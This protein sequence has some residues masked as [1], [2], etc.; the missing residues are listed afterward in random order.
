LVPSPLYRLYRRHQVRG[1]IESFRPRTVEHRYGK[2]S[3]RVR[4]EDPLAE[5]WYDQDWDEPPEVAF[6]RSHGLSAG[7]TVFDLGAHQGVVA[8]LLA[9]VVG[10]SGSV[11][12]VEATSHNA[13]VA[14]INRDLNGATQVTIRHAAVA[15]EP[16]KVFVGEELN[17]RA[18]RGRI[19]QTETEAITIDHLTV[20]HGPPDAILVDV[21][22]FEVEALRGAAATL[23]ARPALAIEVHTG[24][25]LE[26]AGGSVD[27]LLGLL[28]GYELWAL[29]PAEDERTQSFQPLRSIPDTRFFLGAVAP[30]RSRT[31]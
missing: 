18:S 9:D 31:L 15:A 14:T 28:N 30:G 26:E 6:L 11:V 19:G 25:G 3:L 23:E 4:L 10:T 21:E 20:N 1:L 8:L 13:R 5:A 29:T 17:A 12:A 7:G 22:G 24:V 16:G 2:K 27:E